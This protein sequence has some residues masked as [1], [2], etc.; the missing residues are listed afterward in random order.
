MAGRTATG[1]RASEAASGFETAD[2]FPPS[3]W[4]VA[5]MQGA[6]GLRDLETERACAV[7]EH[8]RRARYSAQ[9]SRAVGAAA[10]LFLRLRRDEGGDVWVAHPVYAY[11]HPR[12]MATGQRDAPNNSVTRPRSHRLPASW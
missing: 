12:A 10:P 3:G 4:R 7:A 11:R 6:M 5:P 8:G 9:R 1:G 2:F